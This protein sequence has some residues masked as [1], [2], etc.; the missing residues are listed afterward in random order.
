MLNGPL[1]LFEEDYDKG[2]YEIFKYLKDNEIKTLVGGGDSLH[3]V[4][5]LDFNDAFYHVSTGGGATLEYLTG[6]VLPGLEV[7]DEK[8]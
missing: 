7:I 8:C 6:E 1:G 4:D 5:I 3:A 2:T